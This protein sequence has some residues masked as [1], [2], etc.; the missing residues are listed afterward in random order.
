MSLFVTIFVIINYIL[1]QTKQNINDF[2]LTNYFF[3]S[4]VQGEKDG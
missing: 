2:F 1:V 3:K 4:C